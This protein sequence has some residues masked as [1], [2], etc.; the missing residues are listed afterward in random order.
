MRSDLQKVFA[1][2]YTRLS[3]S[4]TKEVEKP[5]GLMMERI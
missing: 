5:V 4:D 1:V 3:S 2:N